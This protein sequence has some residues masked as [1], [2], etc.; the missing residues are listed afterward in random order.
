MEQPTVNTLNLTASFGNEDVDLARSLI[1]PDAEA[2]GRLRIL[3]DGSL[4]MLQQEW[5]G[6]FG[7]IWLAVSMYAVPGAPSPHS[8]GHA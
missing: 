5:S 6:M 2:T 3:C 8:A 1:G 4:S 7:P